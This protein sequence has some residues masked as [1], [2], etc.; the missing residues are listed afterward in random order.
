MVPHLDIKCRADQGRWYSAA[1]VKVVLHSLFGPAV[2]VI[3]NILSFALFYHVPLQERQVL[4]SARFHH[5]PYIIED[6]KW[7]RVGRSI[8]SAA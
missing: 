8:V 4:F 3:G 2:I 7:S 6:L 1:T 5:S